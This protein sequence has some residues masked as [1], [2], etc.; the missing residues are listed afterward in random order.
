MSY[1]EHLKQLIENHE[2]RLKKLK[3]QE[4]LHGKSVDPHIL[5]EIEDI[6]KEIRKLQTELDEK[7]PGSQIVELLDSLDTEPIS[8]SAQNRI[9]EIKNMGDSDKAI[10]QCEKALK[11]RE[12][13]LHY[14]A[15]Y[16][17]GRFYL[18]LASIYLNEDKRNLKLAAKHYLESRDE[19]HSR[20]SHLEGLAELGLAITQDKLNKLEEAIYTLDRAD[21][22]AN[23]VTIYRVDEIALTKLDQTIK[24]EHKKVSDRLLAEEEPNFRRT[25]DDTEKRLLVFDISV[26]E[27][28]IGTGGTIDLNLLS[29]DDYKRTALETA[30]AVIIDP[31]KRRSIRR[32]DYILEI[33]KKVDKAIDGLRHGDWLLIQ[34]KE[35]PKELNGRRVAIFSRNSPEEI[36]GTC[37][38]LKT[39]SHAKDHYFLK[40]Q[41]KSASIVITHY[42]SD[43]T[44][45]IESYYK[46]HN[47]IETKLAFDVRVSGEVIDQ[48]PQGAR[49]KIVKDFIWQIPIVGDI[50]D[51]RSRPIAEEDI[52]RY[53]DLRKKESKGGY[54]YFG[55]E[56]KRKPATN[57]VIK[58]ALIRQQEDV[59]DGEIAAIVVTT[60][61]SE[62]SIKELRKYHLYEKR[63]D[64]RHWFLEAGEYSNKDLVV[65]PDG[66]NTKAIRDLYSKKTLHS[67]ITF[68]EHAELEIVG[69]YIDSIEEKKEE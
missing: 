14:N 56:D 58:Y 3:E 69:K 66:V 45:K 51:G 50:A 11:R 23:R 43:D 63:Q 26:G 54:S 59:K 18:L 37:A 53:I 62:R 10:E 12:S 29:L 31:K 34:S 64:L 16:D 20:Q 61:D 46:G 19:F 41:N 49:K 40:A 48:I 8:E 7:Y 13:S 36:E 67:E 25:S 6:E 38:S 21:E 33:D 9:T 15:P 1:R 17:R 28:C 57:N 55:V 68:Y 32:A 30:Q 60:P 4:A 42:Q 44:A 27:R 2:R 5:I 39:F 52:E 24:K 65:I 35:N 47:D 22:I